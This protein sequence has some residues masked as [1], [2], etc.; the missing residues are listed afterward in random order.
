MFQSVIGFASV[1]FDR[2]PRGG[3]G[4]PDFVDTGF[5]K[6]GLITGTALI[7]YSVGGFRSGVPRR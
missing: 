2:L 7:V 3:A 4:A 1:G 5:E 6:A